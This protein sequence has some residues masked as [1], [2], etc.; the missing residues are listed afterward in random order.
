MTR[1]RRVG[2]ALAVPAILVLAACA[3][4]ERAGTPA[5]PTAIA[6]WSEPIGVAPELVYV[7][8][9]EGF[10]LVA[11]SVGVMG[12]DGMSAIYVSGDGS[13]DVMLTTAR[14][15]TPDVVPCAG[16]PDSSE[17]AP[18]LQCAAELGDVH[19][20]LDGVDVDPATMRAAA[21]A[22]RVPRADELDDLFAGAAIAE[23]PVERGD[24]PPDGDGAPLNPI[25]I[26][27]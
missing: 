23:A 26:G 27:G 1:T 18:V 8:D 5:Q 11:Q 20:T 4:Q 13:G 6:T 12:D 15:V 10:E 9:I 25:G 24:L 19:V 22:I 3:G 7:T 16:L 2:V 21:R 14:D 17:P